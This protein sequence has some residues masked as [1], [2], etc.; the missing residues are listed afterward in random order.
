MLPDGAM[1]NRELKPLLGHLCSAVGHHVINALSTVVS[2]G[3]IL[4]TLGAASGSGSGSLEIRDRVETIVRTALDASAIT[5]K[6]IEISHDLT[7]LGFDQPIVPVEEVSLDVWIARFIDEEGPALAPNAEWKL[8]LSPVPR[9]L[10]QPGLLRTMFRLLI[11][12]CVDAM[13]EGRGT[14]ALSSRPA[15]RNWL[16]VEL[17]DDGSGMA[18]EVMEHATEPFYTT[19]PERRGIGL[20]IARGIWRRHRGSLSLEGEPGVGTTIRLLAPSMG[21]A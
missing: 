15:P 8:D 11:G 17:R 21:E 2:Q 5:R 7:A 16:V 12:N 6:L 14:I 19:H 18:P 3:E 9:I 20:T 10:T 13:P 4:R 1:E